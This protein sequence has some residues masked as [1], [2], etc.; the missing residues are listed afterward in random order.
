MF[1][2]KWLVKHKSNSQTA[3]KWNGWVT[4]HIKAWAL[5]GSLT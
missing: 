1:C 2:Q 3:I 5:F 4:F